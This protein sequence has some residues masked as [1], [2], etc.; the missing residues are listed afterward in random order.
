[1]SELVAPTSI[2]RGK[3]ISATASLT[4]QFV[5]TG[6]IIMLVAM[7]AAGFF[8][9]EN[10]TRTAIENTASSTALLM[11][12]FI[13]PLAQTLASEEVLSVTQKEELDYLLG[14]DHFKKRFPHLEIWKEGGLVAYSTTADLIG[15][16]FSPPDGLTVALTGEVSAQ[17]ANLDAREHLVRGLHT[18]YLE[19][20]VPIRENNSG[21]VIA[22]AEIHENTIELEQELWWLRFKSWI[23]VAGATLIIMLGLFGIV[24]RGSQLIVRQ[25]HQLRERLVEIEHTSRHNQI[26][27]E[28][29]E[30]ASGRIAELNEKYLRRIGAE[31]HDGP[32]QLIG[33]AALA[34]EHVRRAKTPVKR[35]EELQALETVL[36]DALR[37]IRTTSKGLML[38]EIEGLPFPEIVE[39]VVSSHELRTGTKVSVHCNCVSQPLTH[40]LKI[41]AYRFLQEGLNN[42]FRHAGG[43]GQSVTCRLDASALSLSVQDDG[44]ERSDWLS[45]SD[46]GLGLVGLRDRVESLGGVFR[47]SRRANGGTIIEMSV[48]MTGE[49]QDG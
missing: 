4:R 43:S 25:Q 24:Y 44:G 6:G 27:K 8:I 47:M 1:M 42:A 49:G 36:S 23:A 14:G 15:R 22:V 28:R 26:L 13:S 17:Y 16:K 19:I 12:S 21:R 41:C 40:A 34:V 11:D 31:L 5:M 37:D 2:M 9:S 39:R 35:E 33:L 3:A 32:A 20:Y 29:A 38:P 46:F 10:A 45:A 7:V 18:K 30:R 48:E